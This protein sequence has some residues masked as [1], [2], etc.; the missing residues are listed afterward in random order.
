MAL[1][2]FLVVVRLKGGIPENLIPFLKLPLFAGVFGAA[3]TMVAMEYFL[4][5]FDK[6]SELK[7]VFWFCVMLFPP[8][9]PPLYC[10]IVYSRP[11]ALKVN[12]GP[13]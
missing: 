13:R 4:F 11:D 6:S 8:L 9:R 12:P 7:K 3:V 5:G 1:S 10:F 2:V